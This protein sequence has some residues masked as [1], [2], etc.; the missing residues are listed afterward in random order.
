MKKMKSGGSPGKRGILRK[1]AKLAIGAYLLNKLR[2]GILE[3]E[4]EPEV[5]PE[6]MML[7]EAEEAETGEGRPSMRMGKIILAG[8]A[9]ATLLY[10]VKKRAA[11]KIGHKI[12]VE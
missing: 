4:V 1:Y 12:E 9:G 10:A 2:S 8:L 11:K 3:K 5:E 7:S 6:E